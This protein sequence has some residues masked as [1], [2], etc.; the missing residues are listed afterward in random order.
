VQTRVKITWGLKP[1]ENNARYSSELHPKPV[2]IH[3]RVLT[4]GTRADSEKKRSSVKREKRAPR[5]GPVNL[6][7]LLRPFYTHVHH[8]VMWGFVSIQLLVTGANS[9]INTLQNLVFTSIRHY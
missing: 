3:E 1:T 9:I 5:D 8:R 7:A 6:A 2:H 4:A